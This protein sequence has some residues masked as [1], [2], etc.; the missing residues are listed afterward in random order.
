MSNLIKFPTIAYPWAIHGVF[1][2]EEKAYHF[3]V[4]RLGKRIALFYQW[5]D[6]KL[7]IQEKQLFT[8]EKA[9]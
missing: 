6:A 7:F 3:N 9:V 5:E 1:N 8:N 4:F 2:K